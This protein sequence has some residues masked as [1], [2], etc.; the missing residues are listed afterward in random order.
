MPLPLPIRQRSPMRTTG[1]VTHSW[2]GTMPADS[3]TLGP[4]MVPAPMRM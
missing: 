2:P 3:D 1:S 4:I